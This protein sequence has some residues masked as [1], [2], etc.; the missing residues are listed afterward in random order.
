MS[1]IV[2][3]DLPVILLAS[4]DINTSSCLFLPPSA[5]FPLS[6]VPS[7]AEKQARLI[8]ARYPEAW[9]RSMGTERTRLLLDGEMVL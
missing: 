2:L 3:C 7:L 4:Q 1:K 9:A 6:D 5:S 8:V